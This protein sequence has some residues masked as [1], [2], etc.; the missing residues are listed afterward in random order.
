M[1]KNI[2]KMAKGGKPDPIRVTDPNDPRLRAYNDSLNTFNLIPKYNEEIQKT[3]KKATNSIQ[4]T[5]EILQINNK[6]SKKGL[7]FQLGF[8]RK[9]Y[10]FREVD[11]GLLSSYYYDFK[12]PNQPVEYKRWEDSTRMNP[13]N[14][15]IQR[16][17]RVSVDLTK[18]QVNQKP[19]NFSLTFP[20]KFNS[21]N[22]GNPTRTL[23][24]NTEE[25]MRNAIEGIRSKTGTSPN[26][27]T[28]K[29]D[30]TEGSGGYT[31]Y[32]DEISK[33]MNEEE[34]R[35]GGNIKQYAVNGYPYSNANNGMDY[36]LQNTDQ[37][38]GQES[39]NPLDTFNP[40]QNQQIFNNPQQENKYSEW[41]KGYDPY[42]VGQYDDSGFAKNFE[43]FNAKNKL[44]GAKNPNGLRNMKGMEEAGEIPEGS[45]AQAKTDIAGAAFNAVGTGLESL[46]P[47]DSK[48]GK[49]MQ[50]GN[51]FAKTAEPL[52]ML[53]MAVPGLGTGLVEA[54]RLAGAITGGIQAKNEEIDTD[55]IEENTNFLKKYQNFNFDKVSQG[56]RMAEEGM[57]VSENPEVDN[58]IQEIFMDFDNLLGQ[59]PESSM[60]RGGNIK[61]YNG[62]NILP[63][64]SNF[65]DTGAMATYIPSKIDSIQGKTIAQAQEISNYMDFKPE[66]LYQFRD[67]ESRKELIS[68]NTPG[69]SPIINNSIYRKMPN[70]GQYIPLSK[71]QHLK[72]LELLK[73]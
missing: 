10:P 28:F 15:N 22:Q 27:T 39:T 34:F 54:A 38:Y 65:P 31:R 50:K 45:V 2:K 16:N 69:Y 58:L 18:R 36:G 55:R 52:K 62:V 30:G 25:E 71:Q 43:G 51:S 73:K 32:F 9:L 35:Y 60:R 61:A 29:Q 46:A 20:D 14:T 8:N 23:Q 57:N 66:E 41:G 67:N 26:R 19:Q 7:N 56:K 72:G 53:D 68:V 24:Y 5:E 49:A 70:S 44:Q 4:G 48:F 3:L 13:T 59:S 63:N 12:E 1:K 47:P 6:F 40:N 21:T 42:K 17:N 37:M 11:D 33:A 64:Y